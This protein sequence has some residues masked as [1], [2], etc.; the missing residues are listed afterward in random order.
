MQ[1]LVEGEYLLDRM[2]GKGGWTYVKFDK[3]IFSA[4]KAFGMMKVSGSIDDFTFEGKHLMPMGNG[5]VF[6]PVAKAIRSKIKKE[7]GDI[8]FVRLFRKDVP[9]QAP[10]ELIECL[11]DDPGKWELFQLLSEADQRYWVE[12]IYSSEQMDEQ[13]IRIIKLLDALIP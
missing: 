2:Q 9:Y 12:Y 3:G 6:L 4:F 5:C 7:E 10:T 1:L 8:V 11:K 13:T